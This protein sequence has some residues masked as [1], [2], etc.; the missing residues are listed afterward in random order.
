MATGLGWLTAGMLTVSAAY[1][2]A[3]VLLADRLP[4]LSER[5]TAGGMPV[6][7]VQSY[8]VF[9]LI[10]VAFVALGL[11][12]LGVLP[13]PF[14]RRP[15]ARLVV[16]GAL[17]GG[18]LI[19]RPY[20]L[21]DKLI[22]YA[23]QT[24]NPL[25]GAGVFILQS[26]GNLLVVAVLGGVLALVGRGGGRA[27][28]PERVARAAGLALIALGTFLVVYWDLRV[29]SLFGYGWFPVMPWN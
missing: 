6:R 1:G 3:A 25:Y 7:L 5:V 23:A 24:G 29:P 26:A 9:G 19:G 12:T 22:E 15:R 28:R 17:I 27:W 21:F 16:L 20:P 2:F 10:G 11:S 18:F 8:V 14:A 4:Q 13:D